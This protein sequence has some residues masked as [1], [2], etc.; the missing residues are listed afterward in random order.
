MDSKH[1][2]THRVDNLALLKPDFKILAVFKHPNRLERL[3]P[4]KGSS[5]LHIQHSNLF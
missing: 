1:S 5:E 3:D 2:G 4:E